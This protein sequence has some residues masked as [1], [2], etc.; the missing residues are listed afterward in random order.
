MLDAKHKCGRQTFPGVSSQCLVF[1]ATGNRPECLPW[2]SSHGAAALN[3]LL[4]NKEGEVVAQERDV[5]LDVLRP[6]CL[7][8]GNHVCFCLDAVR[9]LI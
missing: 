2:E 4:R 9:F 3:Q 5:L 8:G 1:E 7:L 6:F